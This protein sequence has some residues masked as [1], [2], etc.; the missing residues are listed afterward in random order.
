MTAKF[1]NSCHAT[2]L[3]LPLIISDSP[4]DSKQF[5]KP[6]LENYFHF[7]NWRFRCTGRRNTS[8]LSA[9]MMGSSFSQ[10]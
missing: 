5:Q 9:D 2:V 4:P 3:G 1:T 8:A 7:Y 6:A 10:W